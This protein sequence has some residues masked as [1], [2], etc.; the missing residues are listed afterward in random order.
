M[1]VEPHSASAQVAGAIR[2][3]AKSTG[4]SFDYL[5]ATAQIESNFNPAA[6]AATSS[7]QGL[8]QFIDQTWLGTMKGAGASIGLAKFAAAIERMPDGHFEVPNPAARKAIMSLRSDPSVSALMAGAYARGNSQQLTSGLGRAPSGGELYIAHFLGADGAAKL[9]NAASSQPSAR[10]ADVFPQAAAANR[11][12]FFDKAGNARSALDVY[13]VLTGRFESARAAIDTELTVAA[14]PL[15][16]SLPVNDPL[17]RVPDTAGLANAYAA[18]QPVAFAAV[19]AGNGAPA[20]Q[21]I[22]SDN[23][24]QG[25]APVVR[26]LWTRPGADDKTT[27]QHFNLFTD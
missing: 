14:A 24:R 2:Q 25:V 20:Y 19:P 10:A 26:S 16:G 3:A 22:F 15:R 12:I 13:R 18:A 5:L 7:A 27:A 4:A 17:S 11:P 8:Y 6:Q 23:G 21:S 1:L 9:I